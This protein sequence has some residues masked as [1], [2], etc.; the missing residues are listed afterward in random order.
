MHSLERYI[1]ESGYVSK[2]WKYALIGFLVPKAV[3][4]SFTMKKVIDI[5]R[6]LTTLVILLT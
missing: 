5:K 6:F 2:W 4:I 1:K 3:G